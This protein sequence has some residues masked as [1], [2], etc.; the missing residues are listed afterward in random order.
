LPA[1]PELPIWQGRRG[2]VNTAACVVCGLAFAFALWTFGER[3]SIVPACTT[4]GMAHGLRYVS[5]RSEVHKYDSGI[6]CLFV[7]TDGQKAEV[8][9]RDV[10][11]Y[12]TDQWVGL[13]M[14]LQFTAPFFII[15]CA[16]ARVGIYRL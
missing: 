13:T 3:T 15:V 10:V 9:L 11:P 4:Y 14:A 8:S 5:F 12:V 1:S 6:V 16:L 2:V 7:Q